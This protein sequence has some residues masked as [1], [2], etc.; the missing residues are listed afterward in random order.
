MRRLALVLLLPT[1]A[2]CGWFDSLT[3]RDE[4]SVL[5]KNRERW[6]AQN[7]GLYYL[8]YQR[9]CF[10]GW[11]QPIEITVQNGAVIAVRDTNGA[12]VTPPGAIPVP[13]VDSLFAWAERD[14]KYGFKLTIT[15]DGKYHLPGLVVGDMPGTIDDEYTQ[16]ATITLVQALP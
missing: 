15:Y 16:T 1:L 3:G 12:V 6:E 11:I 9:T 7:L 4:L 13:T 5:R 14:L 10:C 8:R 2:S